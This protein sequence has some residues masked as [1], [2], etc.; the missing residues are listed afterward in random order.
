MS[1]TQ[2][3]LCA[4][5]E[6]KQVNSGRHRVS[7]RLDCCEWEIKRRAGNAILKEWQI[8]GG[9]QKDSLVHPEC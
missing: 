5:E 8:A 4:G 6:Q 3:R 9:L 1:S 7:G 2:H